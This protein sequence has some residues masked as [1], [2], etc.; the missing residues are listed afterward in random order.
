MKDVMAFYFSWFGTPWGPAGKWVHW[1]DK[2]HPGKAKFP[3]QYD[4]D[5]Y[6]NHRRQ[7]TTTHYPINGPYD[8]L[9]PVVLGAQMDLAQNFGIDGW[10][11]SWWHPERSEYDNL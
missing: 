5:Q 8:S 2:T 3:R 6:I 10:L 9:D 1:T 11:Q 4:P 7:M